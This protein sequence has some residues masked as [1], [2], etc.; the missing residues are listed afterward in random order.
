MLQLL[1]KYGA[2]PNRETKYIKL[3]GLIN[4]ILMELRSSPVN[5]T[6]TQILQIL[7]KFLTYKCER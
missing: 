7:R 4:H 2:V 1:N 5:E 6:L 3:K